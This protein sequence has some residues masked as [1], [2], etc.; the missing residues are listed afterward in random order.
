MNLKRKTL[1]LLLILIIAGST[2]LFGAFEEGNSY[3]G[4]KLIEKRF[5]KE[6]NAECLLFE[7]VQSG[8]RLLKI[9]ADDANKTFSI[10]FKTI[11][12]SG[13]R[14]AAYYETL[15]AERLEEFSGQKPL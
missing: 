6:V 4:F 12:E 13:R 8:A 5:V 15:G 2:L 1:S 11:P 10:A 7:H 9:A 14:N 3:H